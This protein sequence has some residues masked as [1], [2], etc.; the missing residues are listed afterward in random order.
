MGKNRYTIEDV[1]Q[2][3]GL[4]RRTISNLYN[5]KATR[6]D[7]QTIEKLCLC[8]EC[9]AGD[10]FALDAGMAAGAGNPEKA[11]CGNGRI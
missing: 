7:F 6:I 4:S 5:E 3:T 10:L 11:A 2:K 1:H 9:G 8:L